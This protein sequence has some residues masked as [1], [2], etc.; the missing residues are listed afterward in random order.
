[1]KVKIKKQG[2]TKQYKLISKWSDV[3]LKTWLKLIDFHEFSKTKEAEETIAV[4][5]NIPKELI[6]KLE[7]KDVAIIM[8]K[9]AELQQDQNSSLKRIIEIEGKRYGFHPN[10]DSICL[11][12]WAD[13]ETMLKNDVEKNLPEVMAILYRPVL[14]ETEN[15][16]YTIEAY[17]GNITIR[18]EQMKKMSAEQVQSALRFFFALGKEL[19]LTLPS[20]LMEQLKEMKMQL[21]MKPLLKSGATLE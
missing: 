13:L 11:G 21:Q 8:G 15:G 10:L 14:E 9:I 4:L 18:A 17:D 7:L 5:S 1:M 20:F 6:K 2:K 16:I 3:N 19:L 12:E